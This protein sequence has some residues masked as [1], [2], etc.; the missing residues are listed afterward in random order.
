MKTN[1]DELLDGG[2]LL[3]LH[4]GD[5][6]D[7]QQVLETV[8]DGVRRGRERGVAHGERGGGH[9]GHSLHELGAE[10]LRLDVEDGGSE[11]GARV[12]HLNWK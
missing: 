4:V 2:G 6:G 12:V 3:E 8:G 5:G 7:G 9:V 1:L 11:D 10:V